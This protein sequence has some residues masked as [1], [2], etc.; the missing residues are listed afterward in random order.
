MNVQQKQGQGGAGGKGGKVLPPEEQQEHKKAKEQPLLCC[1][2]LAPLLWCQ[3]L[4]SKLH[5][6]PNAWQAKHKL[7]VEVHSR[8]ALHEVIVHGRGALGLRAWW[9]LC[10]SWICFVAGCVEW[11]DRVAGGASL[12]DWALWLA[13]KPFVQA[14]PAKEMT[15][16]SHNR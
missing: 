13:L 7:C 9:M 12:A 14:R 10:G 15:T 16:A 5:V 4:V 1:I 6:E 3:I 2:P 11:D 8:A